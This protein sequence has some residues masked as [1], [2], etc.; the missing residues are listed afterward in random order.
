MTLASA[1]EMVAEETPSLVQAAQAG[2]A[3]Q[4]RAL[5]SLG[6][7][8]SARLHDGRTAL[9]FCAIYDDVATAEVLL[10][11]GAEVDATDQKSRAP[12]RVALSSESYAVAALLLRKGCAVEKMLPALL[13][14]VRDG[15]GIPGFKDFLAALR[16]RLDV[17]EGTPHLLH[18]VIGRED[19]TSLCLL[20]EGGFDPNTRDACGE[21][22]YAFLPCHLNTR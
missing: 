13:D 18:E 10:E 19:D 3:Q 7:E 12:M 1:G 2:N 8:P 5:I 6:A 14:A 9:H 4:A 20:L 17:S 15:E 21:N 16:E 22:P 11:H